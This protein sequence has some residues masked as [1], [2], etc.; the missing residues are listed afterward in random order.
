[1]NTL[2]SKHSIRSFWERASCGELLYLGQPTKDNYAH[3]AHM[4]Y[5]L[6]PYIVPFGEFETAKNKKVLE[7]G[8][9]LGA[10]HEKFAAAEADLWGIDLT[11]RAIELTR[12]RLE[13]R[14]YRSNLRVMDSEDLDFPDGYFDLVYSW[15]VLHVT[16]DPQRAINEVWRV[17]TPGG[18]ARIMIY[19][20]YSLVGYMLWLRYALLRLRPFRSLD[21]IYAEHLESPGTHAY[22]VPQAELLFS[23][24]RHV[25][26]S[27]QLTHADLLESPVGQRHRGPLLSLGR[28][29]WPRWLFRRYL[30]RHGL[31]ML[32]SCVK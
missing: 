30:K 19:H 5:Q 10:D 18:E 14:G 2:S 23:K 22:S 21:E 20:K 31:F 6:E 3:Q 17:L 15:G 16:T 13:L 9:G 11:E 12:R 25:R 32:V 8:V 1:M 4:R 24:F 29:L 28:Q 26:I 7:I 27:V